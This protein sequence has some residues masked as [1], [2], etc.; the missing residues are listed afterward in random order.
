MAKQTRRDFILQTAALGG[1][2]ALGPYLP[3]AAA[4]DAP[5]APADLAIARWDEAALEGA[6][7]QAV[8]SRL[9]ERALAAV[10]GMGRF[11]SKGDV[12]WIKPNLGWNRRPEL[13]ACTNPDIVA[14]LARLCFE[15]GAKKVK[16]GDNPCHKAQQTYARSGV[17]AAAE[18]VGA[19]MVYLDERRFRDVKL[20]GSRL[21]SW[22]LYPEI[23]E[24]DLVINV[25][26]VK[27]HSMSQVSI[28][29]KNY[30]GI[31]G[32]ERGSWHQDIPA[33]LSDVTAFMKP[34]LCVVDAVRILTAHGPVGGNLA[35]VRQLGTVAAG[36]DIVALDAFG[37]ELLGHDP[38]RIATV[39]AGHEA[40]LGQIDYRSLALEELVVS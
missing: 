32:G 29:M 24:S 9:T 25:P 11:V 2:L 7:L 20:G 33:C 18:A 6:D 23:I 3:R 21:D 5:A 14:T 37:S 38:R 34:R 27:H 31:I 4:Q 19:E 39:R 17:R 35:D 10:G 1:A 13:A 40:G 22:P 30:M 12:V 28:C 26:V 8:A 15:A 16:V 36:T